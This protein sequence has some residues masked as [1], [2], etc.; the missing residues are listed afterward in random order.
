MIFQKKTVFKKIY[1]NCKD[2]KG[3]RI[4]IGIN[5]LAALVKKS[6][7]QLGKIGQY[8]TNLSCFSAAILLAESSISIVSLYNIQKQK[9][10]SIAKEYTKYSKY[11][12]LNKQTHQIEKKD[13]DQQQRRK[14]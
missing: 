8:T 4:N 2:R 1:T 14:L 3:R 7:A 6:A 10:F 5:K 11:K 13:E 9:R 12:K